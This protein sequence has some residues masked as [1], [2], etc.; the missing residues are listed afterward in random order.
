MV[1][2][3]TT[4]NLT[5]PAWNTEEAMNTIVNELIPF[6]YYI[7]FGSVEKAK[8]KVCSVFIQS[9]FDKIALGTNEL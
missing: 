5:P 1:L 7:D 8:L 9:H 3:Q 2:F 4:H 6:Q